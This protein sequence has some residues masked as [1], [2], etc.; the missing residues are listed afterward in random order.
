MDGVQQLHERVVFKAADMDELTQEEK[1]RAIESFIFLLEEN[2][3]IIKA[4]SC[5]NDS[6]QQKNIKNRQHALMEAIMVA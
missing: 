5:A 4:R 2:N 6:T 1:R 3:G